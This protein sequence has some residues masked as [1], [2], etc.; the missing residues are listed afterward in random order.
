MCL[1]SPADTSSGIVRPFVTISF[2]GKTCRTSVASGPNPTWNQQLTLPFKAPNDD[3][4]S[5]S[6]GLM[7]ENII[8]QLFDERLIELPTDSPSPE[9]ES[10]HTKLHNTWLSSL[11]I[12][13]NSLLKSSKI[14]GTFELSSPISIL[15]YTQ[16]HETSRVGLSNGSTYL[17]VYVTL[18][19]TVPQ[20]KPL[21]GL[22]PCT[23]PENIQTAFTNWQS[24]LNHRMPSRHFQSH[25]LDTS[26]HLVSLDR[27]I[28]PLKPPEELL[29]DGLGELTQNKVAWYV[30]L[31]PALPDMSLFP[32]TPNITAT[33]HQFLNVVC[34]GE[35]ERAHLLVNYFL[36]LGLKAYLVVG[37]S[38]SHGTYSAVLVRSVQLQSASEHSTGARGE[39]KG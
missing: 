23:E 25:V 17:T 5:A 26:G 24:T 39:T 19:P 1:V 6:L 30:S 10:F 21:E 8:L 37:S 20:Q 36:F 29:V 35:P 32:G 16:A 3:Y 28:R 2:Q 22:L 11:V 12:P 27:F 13:A 4:S 31:I 7:R 38:V 33:S 34:G 15:G 9:G 14:E 18:E